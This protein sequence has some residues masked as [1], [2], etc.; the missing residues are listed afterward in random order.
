MTSINLRD[1]YELLQRAMQQHSM[2]QQGTD[3]GSTPNA[4][5]ENNSGGYGSPQGGLLGRLLA[6]QA[7]Q[8]PYQPSAARNEQAPFASPDPNFRQLSRAPAFNR[9]QAAIGAPTRSAD[10]PTYSLGTGTSLDSPSAT[11]QGAGLLGNHGNR[12]VAPWIAGP[13]MMTPISVGWRLGG[14]PIPI[15]G[16]M[17][18]PP[19]APGPLPQIPMPVVPEGWK[20][21]GAMVKV[22]PWIVSQMASRKSG[23]EEADDQTKPE[24]GTAGWLQGVRDQLAAKKRER[25]EAAKRKWATQQHDPGDYCTDR[26]DDEME[27][28]N[29][30][31]RDTTHKDFKKACEAQAA[32]RL[33]DCRKKLKN[34]SLPYRKEPR[35]WTDDDEDIY[36]ETGR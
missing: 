2:L 4:V 15:P 20:T 27:E 9:T 32:E 18:M 35:K 23:D 16:P 5:P 22:L 8:S 21:A 1:A 14:I 10:Q 31:Y 11:D 28:C 36:F 29:K 30:R 33:A 7:E 12:P 13:P 6:L 25:Q 34:G 17:P 24:P 3:F 19:G 26:Y